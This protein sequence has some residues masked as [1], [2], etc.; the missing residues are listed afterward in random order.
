MNKRG[1]LYLI[2]AIIIGFVIFTLLSETNTI[3]KPIIEDRFEELSK[4]YE[5][6]SAQFLNELLAKEEDIPTNFLNFTVLFASYAKTKNPDF[7]LLFAFIFV[8]EKRNQRMVI[9][10][11]LD[12]TIAIN[13][14]SFV[15]CY[16]KVEPTIAIAGLELNLPGVDLTKFKSC[17]KVQDPP[18]NNQLNF[19]IENVTYQVK[20]T[21]GYPDMIIVSREKKEGTRKIFTKG[22]FI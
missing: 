16:N 6:E 21:P 20:L 1:Q 5:I 18:Q 17:V 13:G 10:N 7:G 2:A 15:G 19:E 4:N 22:R 11:Y 12:E 14:V 3:R 8:N 9:G